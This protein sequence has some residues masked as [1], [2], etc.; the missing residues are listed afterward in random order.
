[1]F[2]CRGSKKHISSSLERGHR[3]V[4]RSKVSTA[5]SN[6]SIDSAQTTTLRHAVITRLHTARIGAPPLYPKHDVQVDL[7]HG[8]GKDSTDSFRDMAGSTHGGRPEQT[9]TIR[10]QP[11]CPARWRPRFQDRTT[12]IVTQYR[13]PSYVDTI[14][15]PSPQV[16]DPTPLSLLFTKARQASSPPTLDIVVSS[17]YPTNGAVSTNS[18]PKR[19]RRK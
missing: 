16:P 14:S 5:V 11:A 18:P 9:G 3:H 17:M 8:K 6:A 7:P 10:G 2:I 12:L 19:E 15:G 4:A 1:M 13:Y